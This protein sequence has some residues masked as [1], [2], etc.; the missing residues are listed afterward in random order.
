[1]QILD[2]KTNNELLRSVLAEVAKARNE[3]ACAKTDIDK[4]SNRLSFLLAVVNE[5]LDRDQK[6]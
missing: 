6:D 2:S 1:M 5:L 3:I 4:A